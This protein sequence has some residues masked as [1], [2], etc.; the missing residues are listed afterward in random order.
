MNAGLTDWPRLLSLAGAGVD[1]G[2]WAGSGARATFLPRTGASFAGSSAATSDLGAARGGALSRQA[3]ACAAV[4][5]NRVLSFAELEDV[6]AELRLRKQ[7]SAGGAW[8]W[9]VGQ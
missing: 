4:S 7:P 6:D 2:L 1:G 3:D 9:V 5:A 8:A